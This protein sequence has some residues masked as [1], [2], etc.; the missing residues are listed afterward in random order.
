MC[1]RLV[2]ETSL[3]ILCRKYLCVCLHNCVQTPILQKNPVL[4]PVETGK[5]HRTKAHIRFSSARPVRLCRHW[6][7]KSPDWTQSQWLGTGTP[8]LPLFV[9]FIVSHLSRP[10]KMLSVLLNF[11]LS[12]ALMACFGPKSVPDKNTPLSLFFCFC[13]FHSDVV[14][15]VLKRFQMR[16]RAAVAAAP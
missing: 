5:N 8:T 11:S 14:S 10:P 7:L 6:L 4:T 9:F 3:E 2:F 12:R 13:F 15:F 1:V 16:N